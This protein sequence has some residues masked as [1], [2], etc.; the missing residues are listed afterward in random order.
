MT[1]VEPG[2]RWL[3]R[4]KPPHPNWRRIV[5]VTTAPPSIVS[6]FVEGIGWWQELI[7][8]EW[9]DCDY[10]GNRRKTRIRNNLF[11]QRYTAMEGA[12]P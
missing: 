3:D 1:T 8:G 10:P 5:E 7:A 2:S 4:S 12:A 9:T 6:G 11:V